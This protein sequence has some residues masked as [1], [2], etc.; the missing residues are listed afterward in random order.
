MKPT[1]RIL[2]GWA[3]SAGFCALGA[4]VLLTHA[5]RRF[6]KPIALNLTVASF[7]SVTPVFAQEAPAPASSLPA[8]PGVT[9]TSYFPALPP[10][11]PCKIADIIGEW[12]MVQLFEDPQGTETA[13][14]SAEPYQYLSFTQEQTYKSLKS[15]R[16]DLSEP[17]IINALQRTEADGLKQYVIGDTGV[18]YF[19]NEGVVVDTQVCFIVSNPRGPFSVGQMLIMPPAPTDGNVP[20]V[21]L[22]KQYSRLGE[23]AI[24]PEEETKKNKKQRKKRRVR[25]NI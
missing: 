6:L 7:L 15:M 1:L 18:I 11:R 19:Y 14:F 17:G 23:Q 25:R 2:L 3:S 21:R 5:A 4:Y 16:Q 24:A 22:V 13:A 20:S 10:S 8:V 12:R 9:R